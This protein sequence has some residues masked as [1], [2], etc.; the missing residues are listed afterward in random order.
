VDVVLVLAVLA[1]VS[2]LFVGWLSALVSAV[3]T[4]L[5]RWRAASRGKGS[6]V[7]LVALT[8]GFGGW[9]YWWR[10]RHD[11]RAGLMS[12][13]ASADELRGLAARRSMGG[14]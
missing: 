6:T 7:A 3:R 14:G 9:Y 12:P 2:V 13:P 1:V 5:E 4:P 8:G 11:L 10:I